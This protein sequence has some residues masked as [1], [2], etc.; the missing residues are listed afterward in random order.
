MSRN[1][2]WRWIRCVSKADF[3]VVGHGDCN[4]L[5]GSANVPLYP[6]PAQGGPERS[7]AKG[8]NPPTGKKTGCKPQPTIRRCLAA[9]LQMIP[10]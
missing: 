9:T 1:Q 3:F 2:S 4:G 10:R 5:D 6:N 8:Q 7:N